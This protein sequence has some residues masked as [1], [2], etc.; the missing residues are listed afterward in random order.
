MTRNEPLNKL[1][2]SIRPRSG[3]DSV[4]WDWGISNDGLGYTQECSYSHNIYLGHN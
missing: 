3:V 1:E 4:Q 2:W